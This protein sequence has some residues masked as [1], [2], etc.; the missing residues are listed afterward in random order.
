MLRLLKCIHYRV[1]VEFVF[2]GK[3]A[4]ASG[5]RMPIACFK[6]GDA[7]G[8]LHAYTVCSETSSH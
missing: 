1:I 6:K 3:K 7:F 2:V 8:I 4:Y 5:L